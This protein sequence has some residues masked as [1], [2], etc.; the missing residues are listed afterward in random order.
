MKSKKEIEELRNDMFRLKKQLRTLTDEELMQGD[1]YVA[2]KLQK[3]CAIENV[4]DLSSIACSI[5]CQ[6]SASAAL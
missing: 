4:S 3:S 2:T 6:T 5:T 1:R